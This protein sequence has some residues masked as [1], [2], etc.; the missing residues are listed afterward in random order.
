MDST[1]QGMFIPLSGLD[2]ELFRTENRS[3]TQGGGG[4]YNII[5][6]ALR[7]EL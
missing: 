1:V 2:S 6:R 3:S 7:D 5:N 4:I